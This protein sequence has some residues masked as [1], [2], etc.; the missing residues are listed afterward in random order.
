MS[1]VNIMNETMA[2]FE[3]KQEKKNDFAGFGT[4]YANG[5]QVIDLTS[6]DEDYEPTHFNYNDIDRQQVY[7]DNAGSNKF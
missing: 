2:H 7:G 3:P 6:I 1:T 4:Y 5:K